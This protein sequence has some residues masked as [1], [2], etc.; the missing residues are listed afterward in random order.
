MRSVA[1]RQ[2]CT[3]LSSKVLFLALPSTQPETLIE[4]LYLAGPLF[5]LS[6]LSSPY[7]IG[8]GHQLPTSSLDFQLQ[9]SWSEVLEPTGMLRGTRDFP[10]PRECWDCLANAKV[11]G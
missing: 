7:H 11:T 8:K 5:L 1:L 2:I 3:I 6:L 10:N 9:A 4:L